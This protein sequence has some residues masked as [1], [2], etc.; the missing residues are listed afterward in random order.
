M[1]KNHNSDY[2][3]HPVYQRLI[4]S[5]P[6]RILAL[7][8]G[9]IRGALCIGFLE[10]IEKE[11]ANR[12]KDR[13]IDKVFTLSDY[14][15]FIG[16]TSTGAIIATCLAKGM[17]VSQVKDLYMSLGQ[18]IFSSWKKKIPGWLGWFKSFIEFVEIM[19]ASAHFSEKKLEK[20]LEKV[21]GNITFGSD[22]FKTGLCIVAKRADTL[23]AWVM[24]NHPLGKY[25]EANKGILVRDLLR[26]TSAAPSYF[27]PKKI[28]VA[29]NE[30]AVFIDGGVS[31]YNNPALIMFYIC[32]LSSLPY[33]WKTG[34]NNLMVTSVGT[35]FNHAKKDASKLEKRKIFRW[36]ADIPDLFMTDATSLNQLVL[37]TLAY[38]Q[39]PQYINSEFNDLRN[40]LI[41]KDPLLT[42]Q[43]Y[44]VALSIN[45]LQAEMNRPYTQ[46]EIDHLAEMSN[47]ENARQ[48]YEIGKTFAEKKIKSGHFPVIF[49]TLPDQIKIILTQ[50]Q[51]T[52]IS[53]WLMSQ[54][55][56]YEKFKH[57]FARKAAQEETVAS[58]TSSGE[59]TRNTAK[60]GDF[61][62]MNQTEA[63]EQ[64]V[65][66]ASKFEQRYEFC[67][68]KDAEWFE[69]KPKGRVY[70]IRLTDQVI[71]EK[72]W[73][74]HFLLTA[75]WGEN[76]Y[77]AF[78]DYLVCPPDG[79]EFYRIDHKEFNETYKE[80]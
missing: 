2:L 74:I 49:D 68:K 66:N 1:E 19:L 50:A 16:G 45:S 59:E 33:K 29:A 47:G 60:P 36:A 80:I 52:E 69:Y 10:K 41:I 6:K 18:N 62:V 31:S 25:Y 79:S 15:D 54:G 32:T 9:G 3:R 76:Q 28:K 23:S 27:K 65:I 22:E 44:N 48:L 71:S 46:E 42:Y 12:Q 8:G 14:Y 40:I 77:C 55:K 61:I 39:T 37:Q 20:E 78:D 53:S 38:T 21:L 75:G 5:G 63:R 24:H 70:A 58:V 67:S 51:N 13:N 34:R 64:Y 30:D 11:L 26:A 43:R 57:V 4:A 73:P 7:D 72:M 35:G 17:T 56:L